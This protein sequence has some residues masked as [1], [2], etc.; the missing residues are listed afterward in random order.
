[1]RFLYILMLFV[2]SFSTTISAENTPAASPESETLKGKITDAKSG[3]PL[4]GVSVYLPDLKRGASTDESGN[5]TI[6]NL[7]KIKTTIEITYVGHQS[8]VQSVNLN[9]GEKLGFKLK[10]S[11]AQIGEV[12]VTGYTGNTLMKETPTAM[13][14]VS[15]K[16]LLEESS[17]NI[18][19]A[20]AK[21]PGISQITTGS[22]IS[23]PVIRGLGY[24]RV[25]VVNNGIR[26]EGQQW[27]DEHGIEIDDQTIHSAEILKGP[28]S[29]MYGSD[30]LAGVINFLPDPVMTE[31]KIQSNILS[32]YQTNN[33]LIHYSVNNAGNKDNFVWNIRY[34][35]KMAHAYKNKYDGYVY[36]SGYLEHAFSGMFGIN[37]N[38]GYSHLDLSLYHLTPGIVEGERDE[39]TGQFVKPVL[40]DDAEAKEIVS[41]SD[42]KTYKHQLPYQQINH[43]KAVSENDFLIGGG[44][45][46]AIVGYQQNRRQEFE[47]VTDP[48]QY[49]LYFQLHTLNYD[50]RYTFPEISGYKIVAGVNGMYQRSLNKGTEYLIPAYSL[51]D[52]GAFAMTSR[53][54]G[55]WN[56][57]GGLRIDSRHDH[58]E[59][60]TAVDEGSGSDAPI[61]KF[62][63][64]KKN[65]YGMSGSIGA[66]YQIS[67]AWDMKVNLSKGFRAPN[68]SELAA[69]G[70]HEGTFRYEIGNTNLKSENSWQADLGLSYSSKVVSGTVSLF[71]NRINNYIFI[72]KMTDSEGNDIITDNNITYE[73]SSGDAR[74]LGGEISV[75]IHPVERLHF[76]NTFSYVNSVQLHQ[77]DST[78]YLPMTPAP[79]FTSNLRY[80]LIR[81]GKALLNNTYISFGVETDLKQNHVYSAYGTET[82]TPS[83]T[84]LNM[85]VGTDFRKNGRRVATLILSGNNLT[86]KAYQNHLSRLKYADANEVTGRT[87]VY[88]MGRNFGI[89]LQ[90]PINF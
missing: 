57:S 87:G 10:E 56:F 54:I 74:L 33:G 72:R 84:L 31:G 13:T 61:Q 25:I 21:Q 11:N 28:A 16:E 47:D 64:F 79:R 39:T 77:P 82:E 5:F 46:K 68:M 78:K 67:N 9:S 15:P 2:F 58:G 90:V 48:D 43:F 50:F 18:V 37:R 34:S 75:D 69:N 45:L 53:Q 73:Y 86:D 71:A 20:I 32:E 88:N 85:A 38:W 62:T 52:A 55:K 23:K 24:N 44:N 51:F 40:I 3:E 89:K 27:G 22:G 41:K 36:D 12:V 60:L 26:Q 7:P 49:G 8:I 42:C 65:F 66:T 4:I 6:H 1:M 76:E 19:D 30:G 63:D 83:Y 59:G 80:D 29:L 70:S 81:D 14:V 17:T 35:N